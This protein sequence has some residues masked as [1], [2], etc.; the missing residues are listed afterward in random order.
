MGL[1]YF[2]DH[3]EMMQKV[4]SFLNS[5]KSQYEKILERYQEINAELDHYLMEL[6]KIEFNMNPTELDQFANELV[7]AN[8]EF[9]RHLVL[10]KEIVKRNI[11]LP[12]EAGNTDSTR[13]WLINIQA[14]K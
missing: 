9:Q 3:S 6:S 12:F 2:L 11:E 8:D 10:H 14:K 7:L 4:W 13:Q 1:S 5:R